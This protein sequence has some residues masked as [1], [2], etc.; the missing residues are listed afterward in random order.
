MTHTA[1]QVDVVIIGAGPAGLFAA[2]T[3]SPHLRVLII[4]RKNRPGG[5]GGATD[6]KLNLS[7]HIGLD[8]AE[9]RL[10][11]AA[12]QERI[13]VVDRVFLDH[14]AD[15]TLYGVDQA[16]I[17]WWL[18]RVSWVRRRTPK[19]EWDITLVPVRQRHMGT[20]FAHRVTAALA[21][22]IRSR[23]GTLLLETEVLS[24]EPAPDGGFLIETSRGRVRSEILLAAPGRE[25]AHWFREKARALG[26]D[27]GYGAI[28]IGC[29]VEVAAAVYDEI[30]AVLYDPKFVFITPTH[31]DRTRTFCTNPGGRVRVEEHR[32]FRLVNGDAL[33]ASKTANT[34]FA[35][36]N[37]VTMTEPLQDTAAMGQQVARFANFWGGGNSLICQRWGDLMAGRR[38]TRDAFD[39]PERGFDKLLPTLPPGPG[40]TPGDISFAYPGRIV[41]NLQESLEL[42]ARVIPGVAHPSTVIYVP[43]IKFYDVRYPTSQNLETSVPGLFVAGDGAGKS[44]GIVGAAVNG[45]MAAEGILARVGKGSA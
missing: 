44:R 37:T 1:Q 6:G 28:D 20:D 35:L 9:L 22:T 40:V 38:S 24:L 5:A 7:P 41:R 10:T 15:P 21:E 27:T 30:T 11:A 3:L 45:L 17:Q 25:G 8:L 18:D 12:A 19:G 34:N 32:E 42:L 16:R 4:D 39:A 29:R 33:R 36:L 26:V 13:E 31:Q 14:G 43:E 23:G 2:L